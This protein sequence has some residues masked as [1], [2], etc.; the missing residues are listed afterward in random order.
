MVREPQRNLVVEKII[1]EIKS[2][3]VPETRKDEKSVPIPLAETQNQ[4][5]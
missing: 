1:E 4:N 5:A 2:E 3:V